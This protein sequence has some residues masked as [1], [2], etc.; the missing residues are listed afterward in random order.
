MVADDDYAGIFQSAILDRIPILPRGFYVGYP[1]G[2]NAAG[3]DFPTDRSGEDSTYGGRSIWGQIDTIAERYK[4]SL[5]YI[6]WGASWANIQLMMADALRTDYK[7]KDKDDNRSHVPDTIDLNN[8]D[9]MNR[10]MQ[11]AGSR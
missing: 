1:I 6:L 3:H 10:L 7:S 2:K 11:L 5:D 8:A 4:W 9:A